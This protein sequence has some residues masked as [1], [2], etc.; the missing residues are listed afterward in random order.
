[1]AVRSARCPRCGRFAPLMPGWALLKLLQHRRM[2]VRC[3]CRLEGQDKPRGEV[4]K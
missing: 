4:R 1:M 3:W 2:C